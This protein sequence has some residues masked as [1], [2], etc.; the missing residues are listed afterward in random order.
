MNSLTYLSQHHH[1]S[2]IW[3]QLINPFK[4]IKDLMK[5]VTLQ[6]EVDIGVLIWKQV[7]NPFK[8]NTFCLTRL[9]KSWITCEWTY[10]QMLVFSRKIFTVEDS[11]T[12]NLALQYFR[13]WSM[14]LLGVNYLLWIIYQIL[15]VFSL[16]RP[17]L[18]IKN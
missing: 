6:V 13:S 7:I 14:P 15:S 16:P 8:T 2:L 5:Y 4:K 9:I 10:K 1:R 17:K 18:T 12:F 11:G 3:K